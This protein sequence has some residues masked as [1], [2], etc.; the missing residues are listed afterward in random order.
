MAKYCLVYN[1]SSGKQDLLND[2]R[3]SL[4]KHKLEAELIEM[5]QDWQ[6]LV[7]RQIKEGCQVFIAAGGDGT[8]SALAGLLSGTLLKLG[9]LPT[10]TF[11]HFAKDLGLPATLDEVFEVIISGQAIA[12]DVATVNKMVFINNASI[13][14]Y[15]HLLQQRPDKGGMAKKLLASVI[16]S[17]KVLSNLRLY[18]IKLSIDG[19]PAQKT[20]ASFMFVGNND[21]QATKAGFTNRKLLDEG[22]LCLYQVRSASPFKIIELFIKKLLGRAGHKDGFNHQKVKEV[23]LSFEHDKVKISLDGEL[24]DLTTPLQFRIQPKSLKV[25]KPAP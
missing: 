21:Y 8:V 16:S 10:G 7:R 22:V 20:Q 19:R 3:Q 2:I 15:P 5:N 6:D 18:R 25:I 4:A 24:K 11:N 1:S 12:V 13:G 9:I 14:L 23:N 17:I